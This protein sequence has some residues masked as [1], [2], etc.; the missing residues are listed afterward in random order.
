MEKHERQGGGAPRGGKK[1]PTVRGKNEGPRRFQG[2]DK[3]KFSGLKAGIF[4]R[5]R[6]GVDAVAFAVPGTPTRV[7]LYEEVLEAF[8]AR[9]QVPRN[10]VVIVAA[11]LDS[12][13]FE[14]FQISFNKFA[15][16]LEVIRPSGE[17]RSYWGFV[18]KNRTLLGPAGVKID[19]RK[20][21]K[22][23]VQKEDRD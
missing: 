9:K 8:E 12:D 7:R 5:M 18:L 17:E 22:R 14:A 15:P 2:L 20:V 10:F 11:N 1:K 3:T 19:L 13:V 6:E 21:E 4:A 16:C 23:A